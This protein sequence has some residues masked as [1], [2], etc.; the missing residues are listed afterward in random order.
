M[1]PAPKRAIR[2]S[3]SADRYFGIEINL[4]FFDFLEIRTRPSSY[5]DHS[6]NFLK[7]SHLY[8]QRMPLKIQQTFSRFLT[9]HPP[10][11][12]HFSSLLF[13]LTF[14]M[15][16]RLSPQKFLLCKRNILGFL[17]LRRAH[18]CKRQS[19]CFHFLIFS[20]NFV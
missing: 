15:F 1:G 17:S 6:T 12:W 4:T 10:S 13:P 5:S 9:P 3:W 2:H 8:K 18:S 11:F 7:H 14:K 16:W 19:I 20:I